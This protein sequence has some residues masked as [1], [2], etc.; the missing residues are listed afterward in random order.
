MPT[1]FCSYCGKE[2]RYVNVSEAA[3]LAQVTRT[4]IYAWMRRHEVHCVHRPSGRHFVC[5]AS[6]LV[7][8][9]FEGEGVWRPRSPGS[10][11]HVPPRPHRRSRARA[12]AR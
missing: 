2:T 12:G 10:H 8:E 11:P 7:V 5:V 6:L 1:Y 4:T 3:E 9:E